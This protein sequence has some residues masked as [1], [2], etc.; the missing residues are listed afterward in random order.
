M[1]FKNA[2]FYTVDLSDLKDLF[3]DDIAME[4]ALSRVA[5]RPCAAQETATIGFAPL[6][7]KDTPFHFSSGA[8]HYF[9]LLE[10]NKLLP[11]SVIKDELAEVTE[12]KELELKRQL[13]KNEKEALKTAISGKLLAQAFATRRELLVW[14]NFDK[15]IV[16]VSATSAKRA[17]RALAMLREAF[18]SF[19]AQLL[20]P[21]VLVDS[22]MT[23]WLKEGN[24]PSRL[25][26]GSDVT[27][28]SQDEDG[29]I[30]KASKEDL[31][32]EEIS[33]H[34]EAG[35]IATEIGLT[36]DDSLEFA[37]TSEIAVKRLKPTDIYLE[38]HLSEKSDDEIADMQSILVLQGE[39]LTE[40]AIY[41]LEIFNCEHK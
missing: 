23:S 9:R 16:G 36:F 19:P 3:H 2:R 35:K 18:S 17:E 12:A 37:L 26:L 30:I 8:N 10:E 4:E 6:F 5:F 34:L 39:L 25:T 31:T 1:W 32:S 21:K 38:H 40:L 29:G 33:V 20:S 22:T 15:N 24:I 7:G 28:K 27:L 41:L 11:S 14:I 13:R